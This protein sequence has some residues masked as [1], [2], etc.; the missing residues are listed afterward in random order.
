MRRLFEDTRSQLVSLSRGAKKEKDGKT[1]YEKR[2]KSRISNSVREYNDINMNSL[3]KANI[4]TV[5]VLVRGETDDYITTVSF[6]GFLDKLHRRLENDPVLSLKTIIRALVDAFNGDNVYVRCECPDFFYRMGFWMSKE[7]VIYGERQN[8]PSD[9]TNPDDNLGRG[10]K[11]VML[12]LANHAW[13][14]K[15]ASVVWNYINYMEKHSPKLYQTII[16]PAIYGRE[17]EEVQLDIFDDE[18]EL[19]TDK[20]TLDTSNEY[21]KRRTQFQKGNEY[22]FQPKEKDSQ[23]LTIDDEVEEET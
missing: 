17:Y 4:L 21:G 11:H 2:T 12:V 14:L 23:Q 16:Y 9:I 15:V 8:I 22:R 13:L 10:C 18:T 3:F 5:K 6:G 7:D 20:D 1:R 19:E